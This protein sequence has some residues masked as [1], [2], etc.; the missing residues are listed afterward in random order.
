MFVYKW[1]DSVLRW[2]VGFFSPDGEFNSVKLLINKCDAE[3]AVHY[4]NSGS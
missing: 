1:S 4:L 2:Q 3:E